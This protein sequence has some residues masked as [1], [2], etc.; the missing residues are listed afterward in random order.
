VLINQTLR[1]FFFGIGGFLGR[2]KSL[3][4]DSS[5]GRV[6][7]KERKNKERKN[8]ACL[9]E[10]PASLDTRD[11]AVWSREGTGIRR[12]SRKVKPVAA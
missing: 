8:N 1:V 6:A 4:R 7:K 9:P 10:R 12:F 3:S 11:A 2:L 5:R